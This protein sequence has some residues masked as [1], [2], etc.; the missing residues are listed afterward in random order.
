MVWVKIS[1]FYQENE[2]SLV[3]FVAFEYFSWL[4]TRDMGRNLKQSLIFTEKK[5]LIFP[6]ARVDHKLLSVYHFIFDHCPVN[7]GTLISRVSV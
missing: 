1:N 7:I 6:R 3:Q 5:L 4:L 2:I